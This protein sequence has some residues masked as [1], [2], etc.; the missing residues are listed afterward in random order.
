MFKG[1]LTAGVIAILMM[2]PGVLM[3]ANTVL[4]GSFVGGEPRAE[5][6]PGTCGGDRQLAYQDTGTFTVSA[7]G[8]Y[9]FYDFLYIQNGV[10][11]GANIYSGGFNPSD[12]EA[13]L[14]TPLGL[15]ETVVVSLQPGT[16]YTL[17]VQQ[18]CDNT[19]GAWALSATGPGNVTSAR[20]VVV[21]G[22]TEGVFSNN[23]PVATTQCTSGQYQATD[24]VQV[25]ADGTYYM[26]DSWSW[27]GAVTTTE[28]VCVQV[29]SA[30]FDPQ[31]PTANLVATSRGGDENFLDD[32]DRVELE[33]GKDYYFVIQ[34]YDGSATGEYYFVLAPPADFDINKAL[35]GAWFNPDTDGQGILLD[36]YDDR[37]Q[38][39]AA[40]FTF[41]LERPVDGT[42]QIGEPGH[43]WLTAFGSFEGATADLDIYWTR[44][45]AFD[46]S[47]PPIEKPQLQDGSMTIEFSDCL[48]MTV[49]YDLGSSGVVGQV[50][51]IAS[52][53]DHVELCES[54][55]KR[56]GEPGP[57]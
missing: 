50:P 14:L 32:W 47:E 23:D 53:G 13:G 15:D 11:I 51:M 9:V 20:S 37:N 17:V 7:N 57:L 49:D 6:L 48:N 21:P 12:P 38:V 4:T 19:E 10:S 44:G 2:A 40:W 8:D 41:D 26:F 30:P 43:R 33:A 16:E 3:A 42:A 34:P 45:G 31:N 27:T 46:A 18:Y 35:A 28:D 29:Y 25:S 55:T 1:K 24:A 36:V 39:F 22:W 54:F 5:P 56:P 52:S